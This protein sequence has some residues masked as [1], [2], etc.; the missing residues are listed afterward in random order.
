MNLLGLRYHRL[1]LGMTQEELGEA[2]RI[3]RVTV[4]TLEEGKHQG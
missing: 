3:I 2:A 1:L 4:A